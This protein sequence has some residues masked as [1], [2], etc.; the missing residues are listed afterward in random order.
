MKTL[1]ADNP[2]ITFRPDERLKKRFKMRCTIRGISMD[3]VLIALIDEWLKD[4]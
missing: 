2:K 1:K 3:C 4:F